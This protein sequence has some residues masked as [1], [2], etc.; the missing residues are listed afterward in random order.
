MVKSYYK[1][2]CA[3]RF[4][5]VWPSGESGFY[6]VVYG[7]VVRPLF[8]TTVL[9]LTSREAASYVITELGAPHATTLDILTGMI[10]RWRAEYDAEMRE[11]VRS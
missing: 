9:R 6:D 11:P 4:V 2:Q 8:A 1:C 7:E 5:T 3:G 10:E